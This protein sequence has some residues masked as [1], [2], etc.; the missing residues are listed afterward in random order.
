M[1][2]RTSTA[3]AAAVQQAPVQQMPVQ[4]MPMLAQ[5]MQGVQQQQ[6]QHSKKQRST[7]PNR[8]STQ[9]Y[10]CR[11][12][13]YD[14][15]RKRCQQEFEAY[16]DDESKMSQECAHLRNPDTG[17]GKHGFGQRWASDN[18]FVWPLGEQWG[19][20]E[21]KRARERMKVGEDDK[22]YNFHDG[23]R[24]MVDT[25]WEFKKD[26]LSTPECGGPR[27]ERPPK[28]AV[29]GAAAA[30]A[31]RRAKSAAAAAKSGKSAAAKSAKSAAAAK[32][33]KAKRAASGSKKKDASKPKKR[34]GLFSA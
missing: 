33:G 34:R 18:A 15:Y 10:N 3:A 11:I 13:K 30:A 25:W 31:S 1:A 2:K 14:A 4:Q 9:Q 16:G 6:Q 26:E 24:C 12:G 17:C 23:N 5:P 29:Q 19:S 22:R 32:T 21:F 8:L 28:P 7:P 20:E 27:P